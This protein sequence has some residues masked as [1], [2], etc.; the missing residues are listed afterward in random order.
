[1]DTAKSIINLDNTMMGPYSVDTI[2]AGSSGDY[3]STITTGTSGPF[4]T[5]NTINAGPIW[6]NSTGPTTTFNQNG[7][8][9]VQ[10]ENADIE[11]NGVSLMQTLRTL[12]E[13]LNVLRP[14]LELEAEWDQLKELGEQ[15]RKLEA[16]FKEKSRMWNTLKK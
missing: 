15:Y 16:E 7:K 14:N 1:M 8:I 11:I 12:E 4:L 9:S 6:S 5:H 2:T 3:I 13:R 10:G